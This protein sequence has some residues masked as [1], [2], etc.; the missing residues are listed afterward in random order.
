MKTSN[1]FN[2]GD[3]V[4]WDDE[5]WRVMEVKGDLCRI[6]DVGNDVSNVV[7]EWVSHLDL[8]IDE[9]GDE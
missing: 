6:S 3:F 9:G 5:L 8:A 7:S 1:P 2:P 4:W